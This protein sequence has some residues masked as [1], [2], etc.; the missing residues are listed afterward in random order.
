MYIWS[1]ERHLENVYDKMNVRVLNNQ[2]KL[3][4]R[5]LNR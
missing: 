2:N 4:V 3:K 1:G 5:Y